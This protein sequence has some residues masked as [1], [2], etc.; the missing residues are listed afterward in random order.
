[1]RFMFGAELPKFGL[2]KSKQVG[3]PDP[4]YQ[5]IVDSLEAQNWLYAFRNLAACPYRPQQRE[6]YRPRFS[7]LDPNKHPASSGCYW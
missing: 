4:E 6:L 5:L 3:P 1:M 7:R 2:L